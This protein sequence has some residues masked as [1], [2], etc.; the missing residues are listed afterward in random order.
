MAERKLHLRSKAQTTQFYPGYRSSKKEEER[1]PSFPPLKTD[2]LHEKPYQNTTNAT[3]HP[4]PPKKSPNK[5]PL[6]NRS[7]TLT[8]IYTSPYPFPQSSLQ[9]SLSQHPYRQCTTL[10]SRNGER[11]GGSNGKK[12]PCDSGNQLN[13]TQLYFSG[14]DT[15]NFDLV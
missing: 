15:W 13:Q 5:I 11:G 14:I 10:S 3:P 2:A 8:P 9:S 7:R 4:H 6:M 12:I 1:D